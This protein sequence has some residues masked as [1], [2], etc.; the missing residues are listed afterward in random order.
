MRVCNVCKVEKS[1]DSYHN[2]KRFPL[3]KTYTCKPC[4]KEKTRKWSKENPDRKKI[5]SIAEYKKNKAAYIARVA[6]RRAAKLKATPPWLSEKQLHD[7]TV[8]YTVCDRVSKQTGKSHHVDHVVPLQGENVCGLHVPWN[9]A[10]IPAK[11]NLSK[12]NTH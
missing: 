9:L 1:L 2:C 3:G 8:I 6:K 7:M 5:A 4:A 12:S 11:M 10:I